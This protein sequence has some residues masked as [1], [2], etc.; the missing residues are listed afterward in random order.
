MRIY[1][2]GPVTG[3]P[4]LNRTKFENAACWLT[5]AGHTPLVPHWFVPEDATW[6]QAMR[7]SIETLVKCDGVA[8]LGG[9][10][11]SKGARIERSLA[12]DLGMDVRE[13]LEWMERK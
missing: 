13:M 4:E 1:V 10:R 12:L 6:E 2:A 11:G 7:R 5:E 3:K 9:W 8:L